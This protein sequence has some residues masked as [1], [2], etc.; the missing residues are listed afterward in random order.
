MNG[1]FSNK[2]LPGIPKMGWE[3]IIQRDVS[4]V[5]DVGDQIGQAEDRMKAT[6]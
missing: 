1:K 2:K 5:L 3:N 4:K 6:N